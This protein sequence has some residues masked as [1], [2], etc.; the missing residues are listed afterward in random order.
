MRTF[1]KILA[2]LIQGLSRVAVFEASFRFLYF[3]QLKAIVGLM[4]RH[5]AIVGVILRRSGVQGDL[6]PGD[7]DFDLTFVFRAKGRAALSVVEFFSH[8]HRVLKNFLPVLGES[9]L[10]SEEDFEEHFS[11]DFYNYGG[12]K[13]PFVLF[14]RNDFKISNFTK[15]DYRLGGQK[16]FATLCHSL[17]PRTNRATRKYRKDYTKARWI[18]SC[19][20]EG[21][22]SPLTYSKVL[23]EGQGLRSLVSEAIEV[24]SE[25]EHFPTE[26]VK[27]WGVPEK[28]LKKLADQFTDEDRKSNL[29]LSM[30]RP[31]K[32]CGLLLE[33]EEKS[34]EKVFPVFKLSHALSF[35]YRMPFSGENRELLKCADPLA[36][37]LYQKEHYCLAA[38]THHWLQE[39]DTEFPIMLLKQHLIEAVTLIHSVVRRDDSNYLLDLLFGQI[40]PLRI[41]ME[42]NLFFTSLESLEKAYLQALSWTS[43][44]KEFYALYVESK[45]EKIDKIKSI[46][47]WKAFSPML[48]TELDHVRRVRKARRSKILKP[49]RRKATQEV[50]PPSPS[51]WEIHGSST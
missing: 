41:A 42:E 5:P 47:I 25:V 30:Y 33:S 29:S 13:T 23:P 18:L 51:V 44:A 48:E 20:K 22:V 32:F 1:R 34:S 9:F 12:D 8:R 19:M 16:F 6:S 14:H 37:A 49:Q 7:S 24:L 43:E 40:I 36:F 21:K 28:G 4:T 38:R 50:F 2:V 46:E 17:R 10:V 35:P 3:L 45:L 15:I 31:F 26:V 11:H 39:M 27:F